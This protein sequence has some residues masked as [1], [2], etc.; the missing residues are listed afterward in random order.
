MEQLTTRDGRSGSAASNGA[1]TGAGYAPPASQGGA[2]SQSNPFADL[3]GDSAP[4]AQQQQPAP[5]AQPGPMVDLLNDSAPAQPAQQQQQQQQ[6][7]G[8]ELISFGAGEP[9]D[10][11]VALTSSQPQQPAAVPA[12][13]PVP[14]PSGGGERYQALCD[15]TPGDTRM[16]TIQKGDVLIKEREEDGW[17]YGSNPQGMSGYFPCARAP[18]A[19]ATR[20]ECL[21][22][23]AAGR[24]LLL[25]PPRPTLPRLRACPITPVHSVRRPN[26][27]KK[28]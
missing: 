20:P 25:T 10:P 18:S 9:L 14:A 3:M 5:G 24:P 27:C 15:Y 8:S 7:A 28:L 2:Q 21:G 16:L 17:F 11:L 4:P 1:S 23:N 6:Q 19:P 22:T 13:A 12:P 26:Y